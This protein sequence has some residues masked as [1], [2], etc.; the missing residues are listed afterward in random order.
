MAAPPNKSWHRY[1]WSTT[2]VVAASLLTLAVPTLRERYTFFFFWP[3]VLATAWFWGTGPGVVAT[4]L[5]ATAT[6]A[7]L[8]PAGILYVENTEDAVMVGLFALVG[9]AVAWVGGLR[10]RA[11]A[12]LKRSQER[13]ATV[14]NAAPVLIWM[15][16]ADRQCTYVNKPWLDFTGRSLERELGFGWLQSVHPDDRVHT[17]DK[18]AMSFARG[19]SFEAEYRFRR[20]DGDYR[21]ML[22]RGTPLLTEDHRV[23]SYIGSCTDITDQH[24]AVEAA[25][26]ARTIAE[27]ASRAKD[28]FLATVS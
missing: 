13:F 16:G 4:V 25:V 5:S 9:L 8:P 28:A 11:D 12:E 6:F 1:V 20:A 27:S 7:Q 14:A 19:E 23:T 26:T 24:D 21:Y 15:A 10:R 2:A 22:A 17:L 18:Y 3:L